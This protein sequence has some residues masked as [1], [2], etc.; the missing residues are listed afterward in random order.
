M[1]DEPEFDV[2]AQISYWLGLVSKDLMI[3]ERLIVRDSETL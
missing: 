1:S 2:K 3:A